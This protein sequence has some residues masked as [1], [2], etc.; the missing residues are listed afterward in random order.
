MARGGCRPGAG[1]PKR[2]AAPAKT[3][4]A[5]ELVLKTAAQDPGPFASAL[6]FAMAIINDPG[7]DIDA[8]IRLAIAA[9]P[10]QHPKLE[11]VGQGKK[12]AK[13]EA[14][15]TAASGRFAPPPAPKLVVN[16][17]G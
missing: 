4:K 7:A 6:E 13:A 8:R 3:V 16:N 9:M 2:T 15:K 12:D 17:G 1:R 11:S 5:A 14:A 10:F